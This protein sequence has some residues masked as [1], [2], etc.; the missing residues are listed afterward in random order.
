MLQGEIEER[1]A[2]VIIAQMLFLESE[3]PNADISLY[4][5]SPGGLVSA[6][7][8]ILDTMQHIRP[9]V[10]TIGMGQVASMASVLLAG[11]EK[12]K[13]VA[14]PNARIMIHQPLAG[15]QGQ[16]TDMEIHVREYSKT[17]ERLIQLMSEFTGQPEKT[18][19][20]AMERDNFMNAREAMNFGLI[21]E[22]LTKK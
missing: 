8:A 14:L 1:M 7:L 16:V 10:A 17:K 2:N 22:I 20:D 18:L 21:D 5:Q 3:N 11:G 4:I 9:K 13:R 19:F 12:G 15:T 6:G